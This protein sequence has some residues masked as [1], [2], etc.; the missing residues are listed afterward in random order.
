[1]MAVGSALVATG[2]VLYVYGLQNLLACPAYPGSVCPTG[3]G[4]WPNEAWAGVAMMAVG[5]PLLG[6]GIATYVVGG[7]QMNKAHRLM[8]RISLAPT[9]GPHG[10]TGAAAG[11]RLQF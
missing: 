1:M 4:L 6:G 10:L 2:V 8:G 3:S 9:V 5:G 7:A 11:L